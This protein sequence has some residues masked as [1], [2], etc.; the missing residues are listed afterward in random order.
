MSGEGAK[1]SR[2]FNRMIIL[3]LDATRRIKKNRHCDG[4]RHEVQCGCKAPCLARFHIIG[5]WRNAG[6]LKTCYL[7]CRPTLNG[8]WDLL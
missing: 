1:K 8:T 7:V 6:Q 2:K 3:F 5:L 4:W